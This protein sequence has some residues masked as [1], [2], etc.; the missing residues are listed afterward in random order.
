MTK[1]SKSDIQERWVSEKKEWKS[2]EDYLLFLKQKKA[3]QFSSEYCQDKYVLDYGCGSGYGTARLSNYA[4][5][6]IGVDISE[7]VIEY[8]TR[9]YRLPNLSFQKIYPNYSLPF[10][11]KLFDV[12]VSF[13]VIEHLPN[14]QR[15]LFEL[16]R[17]LKDRGTLF[18]TTP[19][20]VHRLLP[21]QKP[22]NPEH[23]REYSLRRLNK[24][25]T[26]VFKK[27]KIMGVYG[28][29]EINAIECKR[30][31]QTPFKAWV[32]QPGKRAL[33]VVLP[34]SVVSFLRSLKR[35]AFSRSKIVPGSTVGVDLLSKYS[36]DDFTVEDSVDKCL[37]FLAICY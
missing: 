10:E 13:Q 15:Y 20:R 24:E 37:D 19:N 25:L 33:R 30:V 31:R 16:K 22:W 6:V 17:V 11:D 26:P 36:L 12:I 18:I 32:Y 23:I 14:V 3:Y 9:T 1:Y 8:C 34:T 29:D 35:K 28:T 4:K 5:K 7:E 2:I 21:F 27:V